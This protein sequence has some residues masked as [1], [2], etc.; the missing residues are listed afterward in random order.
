MANRKQ[1]FP[2]AKEKIS[3]RIWLDDGKREFEATV[4]SVDISLT[5]VFFASE[6]FLKAGTELEL[7]FNMPNDDRVVRCTGV[8]TREVRID[9][10]RG[11]SMSGFAIRFTDYHADAKTVLAGSFL[12]AELDSFIN[13]YLERRSAKPN[14]ELQQLSDVIIAWEVGKM[15]LK[16][17]ELDLMRDSISVGKDGR[18]RRQT[19]G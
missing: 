16:G 17:G 12:I 13:D 1:R 19:R 18:I 6:F 11:T 15:D 8:I 4:Q 5:G 14:T 9:E 7:E 3:V 2:R 10:R